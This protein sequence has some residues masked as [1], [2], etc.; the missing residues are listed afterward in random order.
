MP[1]KPEISEGEAEQLIKAQGRIASVV[2]HKDGLV[3]ATAIYAD[4]AD[5]RAQNEVDEIL[6]RIQQRYSVVKRKVAA[7]WR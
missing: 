6:G 4:P 2:V 7:N 1:K 5:T 3:M